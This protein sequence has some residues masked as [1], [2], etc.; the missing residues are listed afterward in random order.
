MACRGDAR[1]WASRHASIRARRV[2]RIHTCMRYARTKTQ[3]APQKC[4]SRTEVQIQLRVQIKFDL[5]LCAACGHETRNACIHMDQSNR[6]LLTAMKS[7]R[8]YLRNMSPPRTHAAAKPGSTSVHGRKGGVLR[9]LFGRCW[10][11]FSSNIGRVNTINS[12]H[13]LHIMQRMSIL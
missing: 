4:D 11:V 1:V 6:V 9:G 10:S 8:I 3:S 5:I 2:S 13:T 7:N 12:C